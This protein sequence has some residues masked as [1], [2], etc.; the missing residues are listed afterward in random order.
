MSE[1]SCDECSAAI[2]RIAGWFYCHTFNFLFGDATLVF[3]GEGTDGEDITF[4]ATD[5]WFKANHTS[6]SNLS[7]ETALSFNEHIEI[8]SSPQCIEAKERLATAAG[9]INDKEALFGSPELSIMSACEGKDFL[10][11]IPLVRKQGWGPAIDK[12]LPFIK[13]L[14]ND[15]DLW[16]WPE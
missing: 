7:K 9:I 15:K 3:V 5:A 13:W 12:V 11:R 10:N 8:C 1:I 2:K 6:K 4:S 16:I 14:T